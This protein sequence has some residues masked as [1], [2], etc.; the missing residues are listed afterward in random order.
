MWWGKTQNSLWNMLIVRY[1]LNI[2]VKVLIRRRIY[3]VRAQGEGLG[4]KHK[5]GSHQ[6]VDSI[7]R[8]ESG[9]APY[10]E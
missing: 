10:S 7:T 4:Q 3:E 5:F 1:V 9:W 2:Q 8:Y 6:D